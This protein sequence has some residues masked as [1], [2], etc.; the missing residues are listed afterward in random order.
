MRWIEN[1]V[2]SADNGATRLI[3]N[4]EST[5]KLSFCTD[6]R[7]IYPSSRCW[8]GCWSWGARRGNDHRRLVSGAPSGY[9][10]SASQPRQTPAA[11]AGA[12]QPRHGDR[13]AQRLRQSAS[14]PA[15]WGNAISAKP[16]IRWSWPACWGEK[17]VM[18]SGLPRP[19]RMTPSPI[20]HLYRQ[21]AA[22]GEK[23]FG[24]SME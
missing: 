19:A 7:V 3:T 22:Y 8:I 15:N 24:L 21:L 14:I 23:L 6:S 16:T 1:C 13:R 12:G 20:D 5:M 11:A 4:K 9:R 2:R 17:I 18:M 10:R